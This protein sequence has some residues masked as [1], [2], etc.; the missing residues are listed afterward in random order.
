[1][2]KKPGKRT[3]IISAVVLLIVASV[4]YFLFNPQLWS[5][6]FQKQ[7]DIVFADATD[8][9]EIQFRHFSGERTNQLPEDMGSGAAWFDYNRDGRQ[10]LFIANIAGPLSLTDEE[11]ENSPAHSMLY[12]NNGDGTFTDVTEQAGLKIRDYSMGVAVGDYNNDG[13]PDLFVSNYGRNR[14]YRNNGD[15]TFG[16]VTRQAGLYEYE[17]F[18]SDGQWG[19]YDRDGHLDLY[20]TGYLKY[21]D[22]SSRGE[23]RERM[24]IMIPFQ[25]SPGPFESEQNLLFHNNGDGTFTERAAEMN[26]RDIGGKSLAASWCD[27]NNDGWPDLMIANDVSEN[28]LYL[29]H[30]GNSFVKESFF[31]DQMETRGSMGVAVGDVDEDGDFDMYITNWL[32]EPN[33]LFLNQTNNS[34]L[35]H[36]LEQSE[37]YGT[38]ASTEELV[39]WGTAFFDFDNDTY[40]D[41]FVTNGSTNTEEKDSLELV[42]M[43]NQ[44]FWN[45]GT[46]EG[47]TDATGHVG[48]DVGRPVV[49]RG[50][51]FADYDNDGDVDVFIVNHGHSGILLQN[52]NKNRNNWI[53]VSLEGTLSNRSAIGARLQLK[54]GGRSFIREVGTQPSYLSHNSLIQHFGLEKNSGV[55]SLVVSWPSGDSQIFTDLPVNSFVHVKEG[56]ED[57]EIKK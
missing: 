15:G 35:Y 48:D 55:D 43:P 16:N 19:D 33:E 14:L 22:I 56:R 3:F 57:V 9:A 51:A 50:A 41:L 46:G 7:P 44:F 23:Q 36:F 49:G 28:T 5:T 27:F 29:N 2:N 12:R 52:Q 32:M 47:F 26:A 8:Q 53:A 45:R 39:G 38:A 17:G 42:A 6:L 30:E 11:R 54:T 21:T 18:W 34:S 4:G 1:M 24:S 37:P 10:D 40:L 13:W 31:A 25:L 20:V